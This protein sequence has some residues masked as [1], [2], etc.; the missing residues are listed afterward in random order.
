MRYFIHPTDRPFNEDTDPFFPDRASAHAN[1]TPGHSI[2]LEESYRDADIWHSREYHKACNRPVPWHGRKDIP[3][4]LAFHYPYRSETLGYIAYTPDYERG[5]LD[6]QLRVRPGK[7]LTQFLPDLAEYHQEWIHA[8]GLSDEDYTAWQERQ[9]IV[10]HTLQFARTAEDI[11]KAYYRGPSSCMSRG[12]HGSKAQEYGWSHCEVPPVSV[13]GDSDLAIAYFGDIADVSARAIVW[14]DRFLFGRI[15]GNDD[16]LRVLLRNAGY[17]HGSMSGA[18][19]RKIRCCD[20]YLLPYVDGCEG[21]EHAG[22]EWFILTKES[23][24][25]DA[26]TTGGCTNPVASDEESYSCANCGESIDEDETYCQSCEDARWTCENCDHESF[27]WGDCVNTENGR[28]LCQDCANEESRSCAVCD[29]EW[30]DGDLRLRERRQRDADGVSDICQGCASEGYRHC[31]T[32]EEWTIH[33]DGV[34]ADCERMDT[35][36]DTT[37]D[38][39]LDAPIVEQWYTDSDGCRFDS[40]QTWFV[41]GP[42]VYIWS[43]AQIVLGAWETAYTGLARNWTFD[44]QFKP[45]PEPTVQTVELVCPF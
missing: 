4:T 18:K 21:A 1:L 6:R 45:I 36:D 27:D 42:N 13:Y 15:Y 14:P 16:I 40:Q 34:C 44:D 37:A 22:S 17:S 23:S 12:L 10:G 30:H 31:D 7:Y 25:Y 39:P 5:C 32:C 9:K 29:T 28:S 35:P 26:Q 19:I 24:D 43:N 11:C 20:G 41:R 3:D 33:E 8:C 2:T 38:L